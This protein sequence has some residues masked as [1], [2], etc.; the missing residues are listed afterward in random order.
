MNAVA[1]QRA[2]QLPNESVVECTVALCGDMKKLDIFLAAELKVKTPPGMD[3]ETMVSIV[4]K[5]NEVI[6]LCTF[7]S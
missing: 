7:N 4:N 3:R 5:A 1:M 6:F 2:I